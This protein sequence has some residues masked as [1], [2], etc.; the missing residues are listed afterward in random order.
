MT[1]NITIYEKNP[2]MIFQSRIYHKL[3]VAT[4]FKFIW[5]KLACE[6]IQNNRVLAEQGWLDPPGTQTVRR[7]WQSWRQSS[8]DGL[9]DTN[10]KAKWAEKASNQRTAIAAAR[11]LLWKSLN[12]GHPNREPSKHETLNQSW[13]NVGSQ[14]TTVVQY[15]PNIGS[16]S[17]VCWE[18]CN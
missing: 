4:V 6:L 7:S 1:K 11:W 8:I 2:K 14:S 13:G 3:L 15:Y 17:R 10:L 12:W 18:E 9:S 16:T 5:N